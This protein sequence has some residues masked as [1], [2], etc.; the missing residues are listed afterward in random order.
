MNKILVCIVLLFLANIAEAQRYCYNPDCAMC[1]N[2]FG[3]ITNVIKIQTN[4]TPQKTIEAILK[5]IPPRENEVIYDLGC[6]DARFLIAAVQKY[7][8]KAVGI[9]KDKAVAASTW[10][11]VKGL[12][13]DDKIKIYY[14]DITKSDYSKADYIYVYLYPDLLK[15]L[16]LSKAKVVL[17]YMHELPDSEKLIINGQ[18][19]YLKVN[20]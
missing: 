2:L 9:E 3:T 10:A 20:E 14:G 1:N 12:R 15:K 5:A 13:L 19:V 6:G 18:S 17:S 8:C 7:G 11:K 4:Y 16:D